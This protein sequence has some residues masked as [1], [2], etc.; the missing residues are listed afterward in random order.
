MG[1]D[2]GA[3]VYPPGCMATLAGCTAGYTSIPTPLACTCTNLP[4]GDGQFTWI[5]P[6]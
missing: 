1:S 3:F 4:T 5:C 2:A 6:D